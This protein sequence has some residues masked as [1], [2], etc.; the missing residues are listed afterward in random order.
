M[1]KWMTK[2]KAVQTA[3]LFS[4]DLPLGRPYL[5]RLNS[6]LRNLKIKSFEFAK[7]PR[8]LAI[9]SRPAVELVIGE[10]FGWLVPGFWSFC[11]VFMTLILC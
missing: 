7:A 9:F 5:R 2:R 1:V 11:T 4:F 10:S 6:P 8:G 3:F